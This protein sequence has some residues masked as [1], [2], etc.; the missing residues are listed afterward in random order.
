[1]TPDETTAIIDVIG[2]LWTITKQTPEKG[3]YSPRMI[4]ELRDRIHKYSYEAAEAILS[5]MRFE[6]GNQ[7]RPSLDKL[8]SRLTEAGRASGYDRNYMAVHDGVE[9]HP[10]VYWK[11]HYSDPAVFAAKVAELNRDEPDKG[12]Y[13]A[14]ECRTQWG[15]GYGRDQDARSSA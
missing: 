2:E 13:F 6:P 7:T 3:G 11:N 5:A 9:R 12:N 4:H 10:L 15:D 1:M 14:K 8:M